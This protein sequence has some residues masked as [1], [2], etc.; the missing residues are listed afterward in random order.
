MTGENSLSGVF[1]IFSRSFD[2]VA[3]KLAIVHDSQ[4]TLLS[5][6]IGSS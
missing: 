1:D 3:E 5:S 6:F 2:T 4:Q